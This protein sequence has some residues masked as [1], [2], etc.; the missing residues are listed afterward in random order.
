MRIAKQ[1]DCFGCAAPIAQAA[2][3]VKREIQESYS[4]FCLSPNISASLLFLTISAHFWE[5]IKIH[6]IPANNKPKNHE[7]CAAIRLNIRIVLKHP[8]KFIPALQKSYQNG[9]ERGFVILFNQSNSYGIL[10]DIQFPLFTPPVYPLILLKILYNPQ[11]PLM[12]IKT[13]QMCIIIH[14]ALLNWSGILLY[15]IVMRLKW[16][17]TLLYWSG[18]SYLRSEMLLY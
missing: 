2:P 13:Q 5:T 7:N 15:W 4:F 17:E 6:L 11:N 1:F 3:L 12:C 8:E 14:R 10:M 16:S 18:I 9:Y